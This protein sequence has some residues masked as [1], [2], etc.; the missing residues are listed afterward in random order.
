[1][2][3]LLEAPGEE[4]FSG[5]KQTRNKNRTCEELSPYAKEFFTTFLKRR[6]EFQPP[7]GKAY[8]RRFDGSKNELGDWPT[9]AWLEDGSKIKM[10]II[11]FRL[12][13]GQD[14]KDKSTV[15]KPY[16]ENFMKM[17][18][19]GTL[20]LISDVHVWLFICGNVEANAQVTGLTQSE[21]FLDDYVR[22]RTVYLPSKF[23]R[24]G[25]FSASNKLAKEV[26]LMT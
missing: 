19:A 3:V 17:F 11:D 8:I 16:F 6:S 24:L 13:P 18:S 20:P 25:D 2:R 26:V 9:N 21:L 1:M 4:F 12:M 10:S 14:L 7:T 22:S 5:A 15:Y 23:E